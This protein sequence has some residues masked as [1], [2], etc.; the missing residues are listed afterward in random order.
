MNDDVV[1]IDKYFFKSDDYLK[2]D[3][4]SWNFSD[5]FKCDSNY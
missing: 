4:F 5:Y 3:G 2:K 1:G